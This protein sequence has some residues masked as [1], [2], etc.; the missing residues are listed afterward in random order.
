MKI[1]DFNNAYFTN[2]KKS[3]FIT[4][5]EINWS[6][7]RQTEGQKIQILGV[8]MKKGLRVESL[9]WILKQWEEETEREDCESW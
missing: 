3:L 2:L 1:S 5:H 8:T 9:F 6:W 7:W 4:S